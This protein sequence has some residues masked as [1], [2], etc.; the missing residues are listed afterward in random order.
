MA[1]TRMFVSVSIWNAV[2]VRDARVCLYVCGKAISFFFFFVSIKKEAR[3]NAKENLSDRTDV[4]SHVSTADGAE[5]CEKSPFD[6]FGEGICLA[7]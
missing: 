2:A 7:T 1:L 5:K 3:E 4:D 6:P